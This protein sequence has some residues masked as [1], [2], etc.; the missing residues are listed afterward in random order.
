MIGGCGSNPAAVFYEDS[1]FL[2]R[3]DGLVE[4]TRRNDDLVTEEPVR[5]RD[6]RRR[7][8]PLPDPRFVK[9]LGGAR[10]RRK[11]TRY[12]ISWSRNWS[13]GGK[14]QEEIFVISVLEFV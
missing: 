2:Y 7:V 13:G 8:F 1:C 6:R 4:E 10:W 9:V 3:R 14:P 5:R 12:A 11:T